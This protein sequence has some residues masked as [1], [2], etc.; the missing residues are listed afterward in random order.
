[1]LA[2]EDVLCPTLGL[3]G[4]DELVLP[5]AD[6]AVDTARGEPLRVEAEV[7]D[8]VAGEA[9]GVGGVVD[10]ELAGVAERVAVGAQDAHARRVERRHPHRPDDGSDERP[11]ALAHLGRGLVG[12]RDG[13]DLR[14]VD[15]LVDEVGDAV[16]E[17]AGLAGAGTGDD[18][19]RARFVDD[20]VELIGV[21]AL[22]ERRRPT[23]ADGVG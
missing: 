16:R 11:D 7:A 17:H 13:E 19:Q 22:G 21:E 14:R 3:V 12:E 1:M 18:E 15:A 6:D 8:D 9:V 23:V 20:G 10:R 2:I 5:E 4:V